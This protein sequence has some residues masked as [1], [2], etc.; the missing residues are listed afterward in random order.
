MEVTLDNLKQICGKWQERLGL[1]H[2][3]IALSITSEWNM[4]IKDTLAAITYNLAAEKAIIDFLDPGDYRETPFRIDVE[5][6]LVHELLHI[7]MAYIAA[8][9]EDSLEAVHME[10]FIGRMARLLVEQ[11]R[12]GQDSD[13]IKKSPPGGGSL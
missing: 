8:P 1:S 10:A 12:A 4:P 6:S 2:W 5:I 3:E 13:S 11:D 9:K 7:L